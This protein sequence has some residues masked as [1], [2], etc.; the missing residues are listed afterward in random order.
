MKDKEKDSTHIEFLSS[1]N[2]HTA[3][4]NVVR[5]SPTGTTFA[6]LSDRS[7][8]FCSCI[9]IRRLTAVSFTFI[10]Y[11]LLVEC[12]ASAGDGMDLFVFTTVIQAIQEQIPL[13][14]H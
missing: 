14:L 2:R 8:L 4:V 13:Y 9:T 3:A 11:D 10:D 12:L 5:F 6:Q 7:K 1:L